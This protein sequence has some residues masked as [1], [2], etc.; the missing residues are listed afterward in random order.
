[1]KLGKQKICKRRGEGQIRTNSRIYERAEAAVVNGFF[2]SGGTLVYQTGAAGPWR[3]L[4]ARDSLT[5]RLL[6]EKRKKNWDPPKESSW[7]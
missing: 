4:S 1:M 2:F 3:A 6:L 7:Q 5:L